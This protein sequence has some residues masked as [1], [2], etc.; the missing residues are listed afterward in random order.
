G[1]GVLVNLGG[2]IAVAGPAPAGGWRVRVT[3][4]HAAP[5]D[6]P[7]QTVTIDGGGLATS[8]TTVRAWTAA[9][10]SMHHIVD[11]RTGA[12]AAVVWRTVSTTAPT[13]VLANTASTAAIVLGRDAEDWLA[14]RGVPARLVSRD[15]T[16][17]HVGGWPEMGD[18]VAA[19]LPSVLTE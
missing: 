18:D 15:G 16:V 3:D 4:D 2:D 11:P 8:S 5:P 9:G 10:R 13:C 6:S 1:A 17:R 7:G 14:E 12:P 19:T